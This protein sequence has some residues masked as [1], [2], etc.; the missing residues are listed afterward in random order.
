MPNVPINLTR[1]RVDFRDGAV[2]LG[3]GE[4]LTPASYA[5]LKNFLKS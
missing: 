3:T 2:R 4:C 1:L 5:M